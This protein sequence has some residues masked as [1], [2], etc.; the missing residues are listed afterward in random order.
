MKFQIFALTGAVLA[1]RNRLV[2]NFH[3]YKA[4]LEDDTKCFGLPLAQLRG[5]TDAADDLENCLANP[6]TQGCTVVQTS[7]A[8]SGT[9]ET[10]HPYANNAL[11]MYEV[12]LP[13]G[14]TSIT[15]Q[16]SEFEIDQSDES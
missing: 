5:R 16:L 6:Q 3:D 14:G 1:Q 10:P 15:W 2:G 11:Y 9:Y 12:T 4:C 13:E 7:D 8:Q